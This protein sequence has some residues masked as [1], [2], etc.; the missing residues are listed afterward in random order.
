MPGKPQIDREGKAIQKDGKTQYSPVVMWATKEAGERFSASVIAA[1][2]EKHP[3]A[4][5]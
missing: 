3:G 5:G 2:D 4:T 1:L